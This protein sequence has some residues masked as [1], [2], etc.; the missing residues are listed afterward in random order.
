MA[1]AKKTAE[2]KVLVT[3]PGTGTERKMD[4]AIYNPVRSAIIQTLRKTAGKTYTEIADEVIKIIRKKM[5]GFKGSIPW[6]TISVLRD[7]HSRGVV[8]AITE[9]GKKLNRLVNN[10]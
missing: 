6:Y 9:K 1:K 2:K 4:A 5:P 8:E 7:L 3:Y 10:T